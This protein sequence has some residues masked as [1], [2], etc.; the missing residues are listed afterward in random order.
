MCQILDISSSHKCHGKCHSYTSNH[1]QMKLTGSCF[2]H[3]QIIYKDLLPNVHVTMVTSWF[4]L[5][6]HSE[7]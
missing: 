7:H 6:G 3:V 5:S 1:R 2:P 4:Q